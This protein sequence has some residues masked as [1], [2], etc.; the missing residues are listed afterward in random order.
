MLDANQ[1]TTQAAPPPA[2]A[3]AEGN[4]PLS[5]EAFVNELIG[6]RGPAPGLNEGMSDTERALTEGLFKQDTRAMVEDI[7]SAIQEIAPDIGR[8]DVQEFARA[9]VQGDP[10]AMFKVAM[11]H[12]RKAAEKEDNEKEQEDLR[13]EGSNSGTKGTE[14]EPITTTQQAA[15]AL[16]EAFTT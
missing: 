2:T 15:L 3:G 10:L 9:F 5:T 4:E 7:K 8:G 14:K 12:A 1:A 16:A 11:S 13:V 6:L